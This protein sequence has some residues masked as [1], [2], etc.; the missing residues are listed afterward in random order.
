MARVKSG[1]RVAQLVECWFQTSVVGGS[2]PS[3]QTRF[4]RVWY[5]VFSIIFNQLQAISCI[6]YPFSCIHVFMDSKG[7]HAPTA[8]AYDC[9]YH[10]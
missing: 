9:D 2:S 3:A 10:I 7:K 8:R 6:F 5:I 1:L 4:V